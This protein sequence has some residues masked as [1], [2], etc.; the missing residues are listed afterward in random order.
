ML[1]APRSPRVNAPA[2]WVHCGIVTTARTETQVPD[3]RRT[4]KVWHAST[5]ARTH[6]H[7]VGCYSVIRVNGFS[8]FATMWVKLECILLYE[9]SQAEKDK[10]L[11]ISLTRGT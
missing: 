9:V 3:E 8:S 4:G 1:R 11:I 10:Y 2:P 7:T 5:L 6:A